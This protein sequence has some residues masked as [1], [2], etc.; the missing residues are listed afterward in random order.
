VSASRTLLLLLL[1]VVLAGAAGCK[2]R[3]YPI[4]FNN[5]MARAVDQLNSAGKAFYEAVAP[6]GRGAN[7]DP[8]DV[9]AKY[10][11]VETTLKSIKDQYE[12]IGPP[13]GTNW[14]SELM[15]RFQEFL[16]GQQTILDKYLTP[17]VQY[18]EDNRLDAAGKWEKIKP[19]LDAVDAEE[20]QQ[21][22]PLEDVQK[23]WAEEHKL[24]LEK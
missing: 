12:D 8:I 13:M 5:D 16:D 20:S 14:G 11:K 2:V 19:L 17:I 3:P 24:K 10:Q 21:R 15:T 1:T 22:S 23:K 6:L 4:K 9:R 18:V 7:V